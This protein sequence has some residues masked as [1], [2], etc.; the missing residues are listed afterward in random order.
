M[1]YIVIF[2]VGFLALMGEDW[3]DFECSPDSTNNWNYA[4]SHLKL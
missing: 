4:T 2:M 3:L 1:R